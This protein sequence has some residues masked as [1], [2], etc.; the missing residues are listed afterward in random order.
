MKSLIE[1]LRQK[2]KEFCDCDSEYGC[3]PAQIA[4][5]FEEIIRQHFTAGHSKYCSTIGI[6]VSECPVCSDV[7]GDAAKLQESAYSDEITNSLI[8]NNNYTPSD[9]LH[10]LLGEDPSESCIMG[11]ADPKLA[12]ARP[13]ASEVQGSVACAMEDAPPARCES[14][15]TDPRE[16][17]P[18]KCRAN[19]PKCLCA[20]R[21]EISVVGKAK[22]LIRHAVELGNKEYW[23]PSNEH[24]DALREWKLGGFKGERPSMQN[25]HGKSIIDCIS[26]SVNQNLLPYL[27][28]SEPVS[29]NH[30]VGLRIAEKA[31][32]QTTEFPYSQEALHEAIC[33]YNAYMSGDLKE[34]EM[35]DDD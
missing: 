23:R 13:D 32:E 31:Y 3:I 2:K 12:D 1:K 8:F 14:S 28:A 35:Q 20:Q 30:I 21:G 22:K 11:G 9:G 7:K 17:C 24:D 34:E 5:A 26:D 18:W 27:R 16:N 10:G 4:S 33:H 25:H 29:G 6:P 19:D 15:G